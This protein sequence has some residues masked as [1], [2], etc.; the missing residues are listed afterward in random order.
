MVKVL[1]KGMGVNYTCYY[2]GSVLN[3]YYEDLKHLKNTD[4][5]YNNEYKYSHMMQY[6]YCPICKNK[7]FVRE[8]NRWINGAAPAYK[9]DLEKEEKV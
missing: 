2:C 8:G 5:E 4:P 6:I 1:K 7:A 9:E 3:F